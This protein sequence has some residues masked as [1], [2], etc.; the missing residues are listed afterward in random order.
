[1]YPLD[2]EV[3]NIQYREIVERKIGQMFCPGFSSP[4]DNRQGHSGTRAPRRGAVTKIPKQEGDAKNRMKMK[5]ATL[6]L[7]ALLPVL[8]LSAAYG[9]KPSTGSGHVTLVS[10]VKIGTSR[11]PNDNNITTYN[12]KFNLDGALTGT[13]MA[14][15]RDVT[16]GQTGAITFHG[17]ANF[18]G[19]V[20]GKSGSIM[21]NYVGHN[22]GTFIE[23]QFVLLDGTTGLLGLHGQ[24]TFSGAATM[25]LSYT[26]DWHFSP[27]EPTKPSA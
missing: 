4:R 2:P 13:A 19:T 15:E 7:L 1:M 11:A 18:T 3:S 9:S 20:N 12:N 26:L 27:S 5:T 14:T 17:L 10:H 8:A 23:G 6:F 16:H 22:N 25:P 21:V 24:G